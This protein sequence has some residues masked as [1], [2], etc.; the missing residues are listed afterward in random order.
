MKIISLL[1]KFKVYR[2]K[3]FLSNEKTCHFQKSK[4]VIEFF[5]TFKTEIENTNKI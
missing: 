1:K 5:P 2:F 3:L 4:K